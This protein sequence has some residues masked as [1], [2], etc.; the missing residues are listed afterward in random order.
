M[1]IYISYFY[2][3]RFFKPNMIP[4]ST[5]ISDPKW[6]H[7]EDT[8]VGVLIDRRGV[9]NGLHIPDLVPKMKEEGSCAGRKNCSDNPVNCNFLKNYEEQLNSLDFGS[10]LEKLNAI[11]NRASRFLALNEEPI[12]VLI[13]YETPDNPCSERTVLQKW[14]KNNGIELNELKPREML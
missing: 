9:M 7:G 4:F 14:F 6:Y 1:K 11:A 2:Q 3:I 13:V 12:V 8:D 10:I 5:A